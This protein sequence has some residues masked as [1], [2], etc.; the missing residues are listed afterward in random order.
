MYTCAE[1]RIADRRNIPHRY[2][3]FDIKGTSHRNLTPLLP[4][5]FHFY[6]ERNFL[7]ISFFSFFSFRVSFREHS[8]MIRSVQARERCSALVKDEVPLF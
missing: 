5:H 6:R 7:E 3:P 2:S 8:I 1:E 4:T